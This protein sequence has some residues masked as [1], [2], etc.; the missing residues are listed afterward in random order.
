MK[1]ARPAI[2]M[3][4]AILHLVFGGLGIFID[5]CSGITQASGGAKVFTVGNNP[6]Q[7][8]QQQTIQTTIE[9][10]LPAYKAYM[11]GSLAVSFFLSTSLLVAGIGLLSMKP[12][13]RILSLVYAFVSLLE[14]IVR[15]IYSVMFLLPVYDEILTKLAEDRNQP[16]LATGMKF[17]LILGVAMI[18]VTMIYPLAVLI[19][20]L[21][22][23]ARKAMQPGSPGDQNSLD[24]DGQGEEV[25]DYRD[26]R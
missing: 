25:E 1:R 22:S 8:E 26:E 23:T 13:A 4:F 7:V 21:T 20:M 2:I 24:H 16:F 17:G 9:D 18:F 3:V 19:A 14:K 11:Y 10:R 15:V 5:I 6:Q 12:W